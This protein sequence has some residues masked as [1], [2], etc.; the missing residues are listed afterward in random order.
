M[1]TKHVIRFSLLETNAG[2]ASKTTFFANDEDTCQNRVFTPL[3][4]GSKL[5]PVK[6][7]EMF[8]NFIQ[9]YLISF[10]KAPGYVHN[11]IWNR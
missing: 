10:P 8:E 7:E 2:V 4:C 6:L 1:R 11:F 3:I 5:S 9:T